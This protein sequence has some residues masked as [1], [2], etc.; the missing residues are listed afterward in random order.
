M[1]GS[2]R[3]PV[4]PAGLNSVFIFS[5]LV[6]IFEIALQISCF[7]QLVDA[8]LKMARRYKVSCRFFQ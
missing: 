6:P 3:Q 5:G 7:P 8:N 1:V 4:Q 2:Y